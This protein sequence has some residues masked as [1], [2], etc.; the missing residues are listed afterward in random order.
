MPGVC[1][2][3]AAWRVPT[4]YRQRAACNRQVAACPGSNPGYRSVGWLGFRVVK[5]I[6]AHL[7]ALRVEFKWH[8]NLIP[9]RV[10]ADIL[11]HFWLYLAT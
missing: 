1:L 4:V 6:H 3:E 10:A 9:D 8:A 11:L 7:G 5:S 2:A